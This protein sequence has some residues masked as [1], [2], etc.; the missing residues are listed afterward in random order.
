MAPSR[1]ANG[2]ADA[3]GESGQSEGRGPGSCAADGVVLPLRHDAA[4][5]ASSPRPVRRECS[6][7]QCH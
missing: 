7:S 1:G 3:G 2:D 5:A 6:R 4:S